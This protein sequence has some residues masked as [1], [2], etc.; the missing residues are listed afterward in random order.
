MMDGNGVEKR[1]SVA[2][3]IEEIRSRPS[4]LER[5]VQVVNETQRRIEAENFPA[6]RRA[7]AQERLKTFIV[8]IGEH[9]RDAF[10]EQEAHSLDRD[11]RRLAVP[12]PLAN[13]A[14]EIEKRYPTFCD[15]GFKEIEIDNLRL[16]LKLGDRI[17][18]IGVRKIEV[19][20][21]KGSRSIDR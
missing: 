13:P 2:A 5:F 6:E 11:L 15:L 21:I 12:P 19:T 7:A 10:L 18:E 17:V 9:L 3:M 4:A 8:G 20:G 14:D 16:L 1:D